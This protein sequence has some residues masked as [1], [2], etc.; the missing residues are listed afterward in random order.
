MLNLNK[1]S[2][3]YEQ[4]HRPQ[5][6]VTI[7]HFIASQPSLQS[8]K[9][10]APT[11]NVLDSCCDFKF[12]HETLHI[13]FQVLQSG[14]WRRPGDILL[15]RLLLANCLVFRVL[16]PELSCGPVL[17]ILRTRAFSHY[18]YHRE[19]DPVKGIAA[20]THLVHLLL[21]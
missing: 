19:Q 7:I 17:V 4:Y 1:Q 14:S 9:T 15:K 11:D 5:T 6:Y 2:D 12:V 13:S 16:R 3:N 20:G 10:E 18:Q 8:R 21:S